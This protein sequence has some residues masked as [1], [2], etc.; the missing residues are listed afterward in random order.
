MATNFC[1]GNPM[2]REAWQA[3]VHGVAK[4][5]NKTWQLNNTNNKFTK[6]IKVTHPVLELAMKNQAVVE[7]ESSN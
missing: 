3:T 6:Y 4:E 5:S 1:L 2:D 7:Q